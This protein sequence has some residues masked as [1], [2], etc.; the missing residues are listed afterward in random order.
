M[1]QWNPRTV[2]TLILFTAAPAVY[3][4]EQD[5]L[6]MASSSGYQLGKGFDVPWLGLKGGGYVN[7]EFTDLKNK[8]WRLGPHDVSLFLYRDFATRWHVFSELELG[9]PFALTPG[10]F[11]TTNADFDIER[12]YVDY[13]LASR[14]SLRFGKFL[15]PIGRWNLIHADPLIW[16]VSRPLTTAVPFS[17]HSAGLMLHGSWALGKTDLDYSVFAD[18]S[19]VLDPSQRDEQAYPDIGHDSNEY[20]VFNHALGFRILYRS[21][22]EHLQLGLSAARF[23]LLGIEHTKNLLGGDLYWSAGR[24][25]VSGEAVYRTNS[26]RNDTDEWGAFLQLVVPL[27][28][29]LYAVGYHERFKPD[30]APATATI[31]SLGIAFV[32]SPPIKIKLEHR[33]GHHNQSVAPDGWFASFSF[34]L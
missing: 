19:D 31:D 10:G 26:T 7:I 34:L 32:P 33:D 11:T 29:R 4:Q 1:F 17:R 22:N 28:Q 20:N 13:R 15:T 27:S 25:E 23:Q 2:L 14:A 8:D 21:F 3:A 12:L 5:G 9:E 30:I 6:L 24:V 16:T 18:D